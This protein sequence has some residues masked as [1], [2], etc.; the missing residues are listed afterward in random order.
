MSPG[1]LLSIICLATLKHVH[2]VC[3][4]LPHSHCR[5]GHSLHSCRSSVGQLVDLST[6][7]DAG[8]A[9]SKGNPLFSK[10]ENT[11]ALFLLIKCCST[12]FKDI[13]IQ[14]QQVPGPSF[15]NTM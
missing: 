5:T 14:T 13:C 2:P 7:A 9:L 11:Q 15:C 1:S 3:G 8:G 6:L 4:T 10:K 12:I